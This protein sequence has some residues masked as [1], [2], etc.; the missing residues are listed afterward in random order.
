MLTHNLFFKRLQDLRKENNI[1]QKAIAEL[2]GYNQAC[3]SQWEGGSREPRFDEL[4]II[5]QFFG[6]STDYLLGLTDF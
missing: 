4:I 1:S 3:V 6:V 2:F 5:A